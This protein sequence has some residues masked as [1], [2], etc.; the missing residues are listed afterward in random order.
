[1]ENAINIAKVK[2][3]NPKKRQFMMFA[4]AS[5]IGVHTA[6]DEPVKIPET[7]LRGHQLAARTEAAWRVDAG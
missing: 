4:N 3:S 7:V 5:V 6:E 1:M 2:T